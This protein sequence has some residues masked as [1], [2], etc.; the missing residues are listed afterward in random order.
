MHLPFRQNTI[1]NR[2]YLNTTPTP[3][4]KRLAIKQIK[5][6][7]YHIPRHRK[8]Q[9]LLIV[10]RLHLAINTVSNYFKTQFEPKL[11]IKNFLNKRMYNI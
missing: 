7:K 11:T 6:I 5:I 8:K 3:T 2:S 1:K 9:N 10:N 4:N